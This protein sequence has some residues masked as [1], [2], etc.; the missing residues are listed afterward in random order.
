MQSANAI[1]PAAGLPPWLPR[2][3]R[4]SGMSARPYSLYGRTAIDGVYEQI[5]L[6]ILIYREEMT[7]HSVGEIS[8]FHR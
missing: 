4:Q 2:E 7:V 3:P 8:D 5:I 6:Y 1:Q